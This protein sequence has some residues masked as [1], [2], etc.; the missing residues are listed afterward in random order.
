MVVE[1]RLLE[2]KHGSEFGVAIRSIRR[3]QVTV[4]PNIPDTLE[5]HSVSCHSR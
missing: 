3:D 5:P 4:Q 2:T 1:F